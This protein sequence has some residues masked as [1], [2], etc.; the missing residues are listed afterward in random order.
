MQL[1]D[2]QLVR[3]NVG[4]TVLLGVVLVELVTDL[5]DDVGF[6]VVDLG[7]VD[8]LKP[9]GQATLKNGGGIFLGVVVD[10]GPVNLADIALLTQFIDRNWN[11]VRS[12]S[13]PFK[14]KSELP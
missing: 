5:Q 6:V 10:L 1:S 3:N 14:M 9:V 2:W 4:V 11:S 12:L 13:S 7:T 8:N